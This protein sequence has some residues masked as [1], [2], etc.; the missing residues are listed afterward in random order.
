M[1]DTISIVDLEIDC[2]FFVYLPNAFTP[3]GDG[4]NDVFL[5]RGKGIETLSVS[6][7]NR[8]GNKVFE[9][10]DEIRGWDGTYKGS[11]QNSGVFVF[12]VQGT[13]V[14]GKAFKESGDVELIR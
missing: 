3:N 1:A 2:D 7:Y 4:N 12:I 5:V 10:E 11:E 13:F 9:T 14:N 6:I 8:W